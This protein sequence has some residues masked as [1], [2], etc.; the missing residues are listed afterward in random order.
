MKLSEAIRL[1]AMMKPQG[2]AGTGS[3]KCQETCAYGAALDAI[4]SDESVSTHWPWLKTLY[5]DP[6]W[7]PVCHLSCDVHIIPHLN[8]KH[9]WTRERIADWVETLERARDTVIETGNQ[10]AMEPALELGALALKS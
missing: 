1:G 4:S 7:C 8:N 2:F 5:P 3:R 10:V 9:R 6:V